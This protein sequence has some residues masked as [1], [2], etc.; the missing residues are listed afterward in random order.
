VETAYRLMPLPHFVWVCELHDKRKP[1]PQR[2]LGEVIWDA[3]CNKTERQGMLALHYP[4]LLTINT[5]PVFENRVLPE[6]SGWLEMKLQS[7]A[8]APYSPALGNLVRL[9]ADI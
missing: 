2:C 7:S 9:D 3:T 1:W 6:L 4:E 5:A 8:I